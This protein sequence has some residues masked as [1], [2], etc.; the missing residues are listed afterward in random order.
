MFPNKLS[1]DRQGLVLDQRLNNTR[2]DNSVVLLALLLSWLKRLLQLQPSPRRR[3]RKREKRCSS[4]SYRFNLE[5][6]SFPRH[7]KAKAVSEGHH[8]WKRGRESEYLAFPGSLVE[9]SKEER[10]WEWVTSCT[11]NII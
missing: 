8:G 10:S 5:S 9:S 1:R 3:G 2:T 6:K 4:C 7:S 11:T